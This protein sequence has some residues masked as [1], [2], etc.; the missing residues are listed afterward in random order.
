MTYEINY[1]TIQNQRKHLKVH[2]QN[3]ENVFNGIARKT[4]SE[5]SDWTSK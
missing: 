2:S 4:W 5:L 3:F 1:T